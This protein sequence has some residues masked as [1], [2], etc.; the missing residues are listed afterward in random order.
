MKPTTT[1]EMLITKLNPLMLQRGYKYYKNRW[2]KLVDD[3]ILFFQ[4]EVTNF[5]VINFEI[6]VNFGEI[7]NKTSQ[8][9]TIDKRDAAYGLQ[10]FQ[11]GLS[12]FKTQNNM[13]LEII[14]SIISKTIKILTKR[15]I[16]KLDQI[17]SMDTNKEIMNYMWK[18]RFEVDNR[19]AIKYLSPLKKLTISKFIPFDQDL[20][21]K[22]MDILFKNDP[23]EVITIKRHNPR[24]YST[25]AFCLTIDLQKF[26]NISENNI[27]KLLE[28]EFKNQLKNK[29]RKKYNNEK[30][31]F[32]AR[33][34]NEYLINRKH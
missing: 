16:L 10:D 3:N 27:I 6:G 17:E 15:L 28:K 14:N 23:C 19:L 11:V 18:K 32:V 7:N 12:I 5:G 21:N 22:L 29:L 31:R 2:Y 26:S 1:R 25:E 30:I 8:K 34:I 24:Q 33:E 4:I 9:P 20:N 13:D